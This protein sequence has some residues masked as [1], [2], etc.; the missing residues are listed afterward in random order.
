MVNKSDPYKSITI[1]PSINPLQS[2]NKSFVFWIRIRSF[3]S[4]ASRTPTCRGPRSS[5]TTRTTWR[6]A[7]KWSLQWSPLKTFKR[8]VKSK[9]KLRVCRIFL[10]LICFMKFHRWSN[11]DLI[12]FNEHSS[13]T[14]IRL[15]FKT[16]VAV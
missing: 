13:G 4:A 5:T 11:D 6:G 14:I 3:A 16:S 8:A 15:V 9:V 2:I 12:G 1:N 10:G 7:A